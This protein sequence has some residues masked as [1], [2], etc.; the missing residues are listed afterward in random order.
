M[1]GWCPLGRLGPGSGK[2]GA[3]WEARRW[4]GEPTF[5][6]S[7]LSCLVRMGICRHPSETRLRTNVLSLPPPSQAYTGEITREHKMHMLG[8][9]W[10]SKLGD[11]ETL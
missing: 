7:P 6:P 9:M 2:P 5:L 4:F 8:Y 10:G 3:K 1:P 11:G